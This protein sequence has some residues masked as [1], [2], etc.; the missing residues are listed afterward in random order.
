MFLCLTNLFRR[1][2]VCLFLPCLSLLAAPAAAV[3]GTAPKQPG[4]PAPAGP[5]DRSMGRGRFHLSAGWMWRETGGLDGR[6]R[7]RGRYQPLPRLFP[8]SGASLPPIGDAGAF[9]DRQYRDGRVMVDGGT[10]LD[11]T[12]SLWGYDEASQVQDGSLQYHADGRRWESEAATRPLD[13]LATA[14]DGSGNAPVVE[15]GWEYAATGSLA[16]GAVFQWSFLDLDHSM[17]EARPFSRQTSRD[18]SLAF[19]DSYDLRGVVPPEAPYQGAGTGFGPLLDNLPSRRERREQPAGRSQ[20][21]FVDRLE[22]QIDLRLHTLSLGPTVRARIGPISGFGGLGVALNVVD[23]EATQQESLDS[24]R[25]DG[26]RRRVRVW[27]DHSRG[28]EALPGF[29]LQGGL[30]WDLTP[31]LRLS[32]FGRHDW[33]ESLDASLGLSSFSFD[34]GGWSGG[35]M[36]GWCWP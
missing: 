21:V 24:F 35:V 25:D 11:G 16:L 13:P 23:W 12:T 8:A 34:P 29:Y 17:D 10:P 7:A 6:A 26:R 31:S 1:P 33:S 28:T 20:A 22:Q 32:A 4:E 36:V 18:F 14:A 2:T 3:A 5:A 30:T 15:L 19:T 27:S 9:A